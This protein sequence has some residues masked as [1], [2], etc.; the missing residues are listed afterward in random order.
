MKTDIVKLFRRRSIYY[1]RAIDPPE[2][3]EAAA[4]RHV[5]KMRAEAAAQRNPNHVK[6][7][8]AAKKAELAEWVE[9]LAELAQSLRMDAEV[10]RVEREIQEWASEHIVGMAP[11]GTFRLPDLMRER[12]A[13]G[14]GIDVERVAL[15][16]PRWERDGTVFKADGIEVSR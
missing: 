10:D 1:W 9:V 6:G 4:W 13:E 8:G 7:V 12:A 3:E 14:L 5:E 2:T 11:A 16:N 15:V